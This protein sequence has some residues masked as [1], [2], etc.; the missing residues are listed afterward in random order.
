VRW[1]HFEHGADV[2]VRGLG[3]TPSE[4]FE[5]AAAALCALVSGDPANVRPLVDEE[6]SCEA[7]DLESLLVRFL[8]EL[9]SR[10]SAHRMVYGRISAAVTSGGS[11]GPARLSARLVGE[12]IDLDRHEPTVEPKGASFT[13]ARVEQQK[14]DWVAQCVVDV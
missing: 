6:L 13:L 2:G 12:P 4:A 10:M 1:E 8:N 14:D 7:P 9:I 11:G 5:G 3:A